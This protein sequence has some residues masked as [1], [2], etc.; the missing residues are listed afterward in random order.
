MKVVAF[1]RFVGV[2][3]PEELRTDL[4]ALC[5][6]LDLLGTLLVAEEG[7]NGSLCGS[8]EAVQAVFDWLQETLSLDEPVE[9]RWNEA[10]EAPFRRMRVKIRKE[11]VTLGRPDIRPDRKTGKH[12][13]AE[14]WNALIARPDALIIDT[15][16]HYEFEV[17]TFPNAV[18][19]GTDNFRQFADF[20]KNIDDADKK[21]PLAMFCTG[22]IRCE[23]ATA[24][25][26]ELG[27]DEVYQLQGGILKYLE[28]VDQENNRW[29]GE[30][31]VFDTRV[32]IDRDLAGGGYVQCHA[33]RRPLSDE[34]VK[35]AD[36][37]EGISCPRCVNSA[38][39]ERLERLAERQKQVELARE[40]GVA[41]IGAIID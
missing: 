25:M 14:Q 39:Q 19:P 1:Y 28:T 23:K 9:G 7:I 24:L 29:D 22:G 30:C 27:F 18:D 33:C 41:H 21:R 11:I 36:Y 40:R 17:G 34:D 5:Q 3:D 2:D 16:N 38:S 13:G 32:A 15:R 4:L 31:F 8:G 35:S 12:V 6:D 26:L 10:S 20:A 37:H